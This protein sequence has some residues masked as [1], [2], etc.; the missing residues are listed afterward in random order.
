MSSA[1]FEDASRFWLGQL[2]N[3]KAIQWKALSSSTSKATSY[4]SIQTWM[5]FPKAVRTS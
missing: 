2:T 5:E 4:R 3:A 1:E